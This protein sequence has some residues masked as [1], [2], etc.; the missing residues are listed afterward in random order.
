MQNTT[1][2]ST[3]M[4]TLTVRHPQNVLTRCSQIMSR[5]GHTIE[6]LSTSKSASHTKMDITASGQSDMTDNIIK[7]L[8]TLTDVIEVN[9]HGEIF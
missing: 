2:E 4:I 8:W 5:R 7:Q 1:Q 9:S 3:Y 6:S